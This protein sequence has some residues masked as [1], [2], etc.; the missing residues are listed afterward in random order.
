MVAAHPVLRPSKASAAP[1]L[2]ETSR[3]ALS[4]HASQL[5]KVV[6][7]FD[8]YEE[9]ERSVRADESEWRVRLNG[10]TAVFRIGAI[11]AAHRDLLHAL[12]VVGLPSAPKG[13]R[14]ALGHLLAHPVLLQRTAAAAVQGSLAGLSFIRRELGQIAPHEWGFSAAKTLLR[15]MAR[16]AWFGWTEDDLHALRQIENPLAS[17]QKSPV[18]DGE[19][20]LSLGE[21]RDL[22]E[23]LEELAI[24]IAKDSQC[25]R[26]QELRA[27]AMLYWNYSNGFRPIQ[28]AKLDT[29]DVRIRARSDEHPTPTVAV[30]VTYVKQRKS[31]TKRFSVRQMR[32]AW[33]PIMA[34]WMQARSVPEVSA[35]FDRPRSLFGLPPQIVGREIS[36]Y[37]FEITGV[38]RTPYDMR[39]T[40]AQ[41]L[42]DVGA[43]RL[44]IAEFLTHDNINTA[45]A[46]IENSPAQAEIVNRALGQSPV[47]Q[48]LDAEIKRR[49]IS[50]SEHA[51][52]DPDQQVMDAPN[53][54]PIVGIGGCRIG[55]SFCTKTP[56]LAC[57]TCPKFMFLRDDVE[58]HRNA[59][60]A[61]Q[62]IVREFLEA[63]PTGRNTP[64]F[65]QLT[66]TIE[67]MQAVIADIEGDG[68]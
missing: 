60:V 65:A 26:W 56:A 4:H 37:V 38:R 36:R 40:A 49:S 50:T 10:S 53:G 20:L 48:K 24:R 27:A 25:L 3:R 62:S 46:Y 7:Y 1:V 28:I 23:H 14:D 2:S 22:N 19:A 43:N 33:T 13:A 41:R 17:P 42:A 67:A 63:T 31:R 58:V 52:L 61:A 35:G 11:E 45:N 55:Q 59:L 8:D 9:V 16:L 66:Q 5:P 18:A 39:H 30:R 68:S 6:H 57:Y 15:A 29:E 47:F 51:R 21:Q 64:A 12:A 44:L 32:R 34:A 54:Y